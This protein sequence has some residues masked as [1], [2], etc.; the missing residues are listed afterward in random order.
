MTGK[1]EWYLS[2]VLHA[3]YINE[4]P[5]TA[6]F[7]ERLASRIGVKHVI[8]TTS[9]TA[10]LFLAIKA[11]GIGREDEVL[12]PDLTFIATA[13]A[14]ALAGASV[15]LVDVDDRGLVDLTRT[16]VTRDSHAVVPVHVS[17]RQADVIAAAT[18]WNECFLAVIEDAC[19][20][21]PTPPG[22]RSAAACY[23]FSPNKV[24]TT[25]QGGAVA[26]N[27]DGLAAAVRTL[28]NQGRT[29]QGT[30]GDDEHPNLGFNFR[31][32]D[33]QAAVGMAQLDVLDERLERQRAIHRRYAEHLDVVPFSASETP[34]WTDIIVDDPAALARRLQLQ[35]IQTRR[36]WKPLHR[37]PS[38]ARAGEF[39]G[40]ERFAD[41]ALWLPSAFTMSDGDVDRV[42]QCVLSA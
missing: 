32:T 15:A 38:Y 3:N 25:G 4:G 19:E 12:V 1:E 22:E 41:H 16:S 39:A 26:T 11:A 17:G 30:G 8:C 37:Q 35:G 42:I 7:E 34:L 5:L 6:E 31:F 10:A 21:F 13:H 27:E 20:S 36:Y 40:A 14:A 33:L 18:L 2:R 29:E 23:S 28:K 9:G 24:L